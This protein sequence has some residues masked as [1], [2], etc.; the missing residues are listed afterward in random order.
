MSRLLP[1]TLF[2]RLVVILLGG[3]LIAQA[4]GAWI[5]LRDRASALYE[6]GGRFAIQRIASIVH[7]LDTLSADQ[8]RVILP[9]MNTTGL[10]VAFTPPPEQKSPS[11]ADQP[12]AMR[13]RAALQRALGDERNLLIAVTAA[14]PALVPPPPGAPPPRPWMRHMAPEHMHFSGLAP[15]PHAS[16]LVQA[17]LRDGAWVS[18]AHRLPEKA[19]A[20]P[21]K[22]LLTLGVLLVSVVALSLVAV[23][24]VTRPLAALGNAAEELGRD[25]QRPPLDEGGPIE[26]RRA[27]QAFNTMQAR[28]A[29]FLRD[30]AQL[31]AAVSHD[32]KTPITRLRL[33]AELIEDPEQQAKFLRDLDEMEGMTRAT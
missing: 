17:Q 1:S 33:R 8:R 32:L 2:G 15:S 24:V 16:F 13:L 25:I 12:A 6:S 27:A 20:W 26:V 3:L 21:T 19:F 10:R 30:R 4:I 11:S 14:G 23:R 18:I 29:R 7:L 5:L 9:A 31:L 22:L 28:L